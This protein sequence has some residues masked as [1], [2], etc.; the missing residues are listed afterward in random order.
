M[1]INHEYVHVHNSSHI[2]LDNETTMYQESCVDMQ[3]EEP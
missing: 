2:N 1:K 3:N